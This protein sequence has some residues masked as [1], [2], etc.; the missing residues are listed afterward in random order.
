MI[1][2]FVMERSTDPGRN[3]RGN[4]KIR[5]IPLFAMLTILFTWAAA[6][7]QNTPV[8]V[9]GLQAGD[10]TRKP[11]LPPE[12]TSARVVSVRV[13]GRLNAYRFAVGVNSPDK[14]CRQ[15]ADWWEV[16]T[17][18]G[19]LVYRRILGHSHV[20]EQPFV[21]SGGPVPID[22]KTVVLVRAHMNPGGYGDTA[23]KGSVTGGF[24]EVKLEPGFA[25][26]LE[27]APPQPSGCAF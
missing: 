17:G 3:F 11:A 20:E 10:K 4:R 9:P 21:R 22:G 23:F 6:A 27:K 2:Y 24:Q 14:G 7:A 15:Y 26:N 19:E 13:T 25:A 18:D 12:E 1:E 8:E 16:L 5:L